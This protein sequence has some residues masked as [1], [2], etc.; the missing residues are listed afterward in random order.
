MVGVSLASTLDSVDIL[1]TDFVDKSEWIKRVGETLGVL[2]NF[3]ELSTF[4]DRLSTLFTFF[5]ANAVLNL[6]MLSSLFLN[7]QCQ[8]L[9]SFYFVRGALLPLATE[10]LAQ[11]KMR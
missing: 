5:N 7:P 2:H 8:L 3:T 6:F 9:T 11:N 4:F 1:S 10:L